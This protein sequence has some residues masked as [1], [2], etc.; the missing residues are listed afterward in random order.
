MLV[1]GWNGQ[2]FTSS[3][4]WDIHLREVYVSPLHIT[5]YLLEKKKPLKWMR[6]GCLSDSAP[7]PS[8]A[9]HFPS[10]LKNRKGDSEH[11]GV[12]NVNK[13]RS[14][15]CCCHHPIYSHVSLDVITQLWR[16]LHRTPQN[17]TVLQSTQQCSRVPYNCPEYS[18]L[19]QSSPLNCIYC[20][21]LEMDLATASQWH[22]NGTAQHRTIL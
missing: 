2:Y 7:P 22:L 21:T 5:V 12:R 16:L 20:T 15:T 9:Q 8:M 14:E 17:S 1:C 13:W 4:E 10:R 6:L 11:S 3:W 19:L 18:R